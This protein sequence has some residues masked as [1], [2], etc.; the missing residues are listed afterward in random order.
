MASEEF[1][2]RVIQ[3]GE[4]PDH[5]FVVGAPGL[6][7]L[8]RMQLPDRGAL[9]R[10]VGMELERP[11]FLI[12]YH[13][14]T[15]G[16]TDPVSAI[17]E[18]LAALAQFPEPALL[19][20]SA[21]ADPGGHAINA[22]LKSF[23]LDHPGRAVLVSSL[24]QALYL[25]ALKQAELVIGNSSSGIIEA[26]AINVPTVNVGPRQKGRPR[27]ASIIDCDERRDAIAAA[28]R[29]ARDPA[30]QSAMLRGNP[31]YGRPKNAAASMLRELR[32]RISK[33]FCTSGFMISPTP[34][35]AA[36]RHR[37]TTP[38]HESS[39]R[40]SCSAAAATRGC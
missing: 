38:A 29:R 24:G 10:H 18:L 19:F 26:P 36:A 1:R 8:V 6:D 2:R 30:M 14:A 34:P 15:L 31:P 17:E 16:N 3:L 5:V 11:L 22:R 9:A 12:T 13:P 28:I 25:A 20:T 39:W 40:S 4:A 33:P 37:V 32:M 21:N 27:A 35:S 7:N 23:V